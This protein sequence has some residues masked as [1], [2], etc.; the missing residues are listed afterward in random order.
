MGVSLQ[1]ERRSG[2]FSCPEIFFRQKFTGINSMLE[3]CRR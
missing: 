2:I 3:I 1:K